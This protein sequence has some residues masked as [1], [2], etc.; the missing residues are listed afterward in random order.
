MASLAR[1]LKLERFAAKKPEGKKAIVLLLGD[2]H[3]SSLGEGQGVR[4]N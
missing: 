1:S 4:S 3:P 2:G